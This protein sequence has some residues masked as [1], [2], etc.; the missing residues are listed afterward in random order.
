M[1]EM[2]DQKAIALCRVSTF[3]QDLK[4]QEE[5]VLDA[6]KNMGYL[7]E[8]I[9]VIKDSESG[10]KLS[11]LER[12][13]LNKMK[14]YIESDPSI[15]VVVTWELSRISRQAKILYSIRDFLVSK[16]VNLIV[17]N[18]Y[19]QTL[20]Q[21]GTL[22]PNS[23][24]F[25][26]IFSSMAENEGFISKARQVR[27]KHKK[28]AEGRYTGGN[29]L[30]GYRVNRTKG[31][32][33]E[34]DPETSKIVQEIFEMYSSGQHSI[35]T[36]MR[37]FGK[38]RNQISDIL[39]NCMYAGLPG[40]EKIRKANIT[41]LSVPP[42]ITEELFRKCE[43][44]RSENP[45]KL[46]KKGNNIY[47][48]K[49]IMFCFKCRKHYTANL[50]SIAYR[51]NT[52][53]LTLP[54]N[55]VDSLLWHL[56]KESRKNKLKRGYVYDE[57]LKKLQDSWSNLQDKLAKVDTEINKI[58]NK[59][60]KY[61][62]LFANDSLSKEVFMKKDQE[63][64]KEQKDLNLE[65]QRL[66]NSVEEVKRR[67][68]NIN[69]E[70]EDSPLDIDGIED[71]TERFNIIH[72]EIYSITVLEKAFNSVESRV[73]VSYTSLDPEI[74]ESKIEIYK[75][76]S[77]NNEIISEETGKSVKYEYLGRFSRTNKVKESQRKACK[78]YHA[79][80]STGLI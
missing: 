4:Q 55:V 56:A 79:K 39:S 15:T 75:I 62:V 9:I 64:K 59:K 32:L 52:H 6:I 71:D 29:V 26:G 3:G 46:K 36:V 65:K 35:G 76:N 33:L 37:A 8:N 17:L 19:F 43:K 45:R 41:D 47:F 57:E 5:K 53:G 16:G 30:F 27:G 49:G 20:K 73:A 58:I 7:E 48:A 80:K 2:K 54:I 61:S 51:C 78:K 34:P 14:E 42:I 63:L 72:Q 23:N 21:D 25:F 66:L 22:D 44:I 28:L 13:G 60:D 12:N 18:P 68:D 24:I 10:I 11:E 67:I 40:K 77:R 50:T 38:T 70:S 1:R 69:K 74:D 31:N